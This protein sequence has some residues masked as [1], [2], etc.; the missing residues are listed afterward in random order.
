MTQS[1]SGFG[2]ICTA[3]HL[4][5]DP[6]D[7]QLIEFW[8]ATVYYLSEMIELVM[9]L[10]FTNKINAQVDFSQ[11]GAPGRFFGFYRKG[12]TLNLPLC[13]FINLFTL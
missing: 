9:T 11:F 4:K 3:C 10:L 12:N 5:L 8:F 7:S 1:T 6:F 13:N 2:H